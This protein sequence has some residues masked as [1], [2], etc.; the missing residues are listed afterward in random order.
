MQ[1]SASCHI[2]RNASIDDAMPLMQPTQAGGVRL[3]V[4]RVE[5][6]RK[7]GEK[8]Q[9]TR[10]RSMFMHACRGYVV[11]WL[12]GR[13]CSQCVVAND[14]DDDNGSNDCDHIIFPV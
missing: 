10:E 5:G 12:L 1:S 6:S 8:L 2:D 9:N 3:I 7:I 11:R 14:E 13:G 4:C